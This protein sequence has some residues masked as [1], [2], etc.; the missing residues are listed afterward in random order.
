MAHGQVDIGRDVF[1]GPEV[2]ILTATHEIDD[3][4]QVERVPA[5]KPVTIGDRCWLGARA[6]V[7]PGGDHRRGNHHR[8]GRGGDQGLQA[9]CGLCRRARATV[10]LTARPDDRLCPRL[11]AFAQCGPAVRATIDPLRLSNRCG[12]WA[13]P[14]QMAARTES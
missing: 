5:F 7:L 8:R 3:D 9:R 14:G 11:T 13:N 6:T 12:L 1:L 4:G 2:M 10:A